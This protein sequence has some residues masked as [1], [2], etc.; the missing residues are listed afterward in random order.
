MTIILAA[1]KR[2]GSKKDT[3]IK[4]SKRMKMVEYT[5]SVVKYE[6]GKAMEKIT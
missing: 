1:H 4:A 2:N 3:Q 6:R 5:K